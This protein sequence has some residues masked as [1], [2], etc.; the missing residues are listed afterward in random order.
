M[1]NA[2][3]SALERNKALD[4]LRE[5]HQEFFAAI[6]GVSEEQWKWKPT[7][8]SWSVGETAEHIVLA[9]ALLF[10]FV[11]QSVNSPAN[12]DWEEQTKGKTELIERVMAPRLGKAMAPQPIAPTGKLTQA[13]AKVRFEMQR[14]KMAKFE[15]D[16]PAALKE[17]TAVHP[18]PDFN[19][20]NAYQWF[21]G[22]PLHTMRHNKQIEEVKATPGY[23]K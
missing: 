22:V 15:N 10:K 16:A 9:E 3:I 8:E 4:W 5:S 7:P 1:R 23:P 6:D 19:T 18:F 2:H 12:P 14:E 17:H 21:I 11:E 13:Q 20:L